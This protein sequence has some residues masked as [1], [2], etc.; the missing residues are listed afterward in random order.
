MP[1][2][3][4]EAEEPTQPDFLQLLDIENNPIGSTDNVA[5]LGINYAQP[6]STCPAHG[7][8]D[9]LCHGFLGDFGVTD[10][11]PAPIPASAPAAGVDEP[12]Y[13][14]F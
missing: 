13:S 6:P 8:E 4:E 5:P 12:D 7:T 9:C 2:I 11:A 14:R 10:S 1:T 3:A